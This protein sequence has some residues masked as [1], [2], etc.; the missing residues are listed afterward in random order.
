MSGFLH[1]SME[2]VRQVMERGSKVLL[3]SQSI[4]AVPGLCDEVISLGI[5]RTE[6]VGDV[7]EVTNGC[8]SG[9]LLRNGQSCSLARRLEQL[10]EWGRGDHT[11]LYGGEWAKVLDVRIANDSPK[12]FKREMPFGVEC[13]P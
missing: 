7:I 3:V 10:S 2:R 11:L 8:R 13:Q 4:D 6:T 12:W 9:R 1:H 5:G